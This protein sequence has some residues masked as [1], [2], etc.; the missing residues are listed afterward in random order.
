MTTD[1]PAA[2]GASFAVRPAT[3]AEL[4]SAGE[5]VFEA[6]EADQLGQARYRA[7]LR[8]A[9][10]RAADAEIAVAVDVA[11]RVLGSVTFATPGSRWAELAHGDGRLLR[12]AVTATDAAGRVVAT[13]EV[14]RVVVDRARFL[15]RL[16][17]A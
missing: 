11:G 7:G 4:D 6:Y 1:G 10:D 5:V 9:R 15:A 17:E 2:P 14:T 3:D 16:P 8:E 12:F 13:G